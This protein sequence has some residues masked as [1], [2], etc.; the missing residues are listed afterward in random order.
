MSIISDLSPQNRFA[1]GFD[2]AVAAVVGF[3]VAI[4]TAQSRVR[5]IELLGAKTAKGWP[6]VALPVETSCA[7]PTVTSIK[8][9]V[10]FDP[11]KTPLLLWWGL[12]LLTV[13]LNKKGVGHIGPTLRIGTKR[14]VWWLVKAFSLG[15]ADING[16]TGRNQAFDCVY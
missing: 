11:K 7:T 13:Y 4:G 6:P 3:L 5:Q 15:Q 9:K 2:R 16:F 1:A 12:F 10:P 8:F 14:S